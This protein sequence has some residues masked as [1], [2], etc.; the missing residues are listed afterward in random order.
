ME[1]LK[2]KKGFTLI[3]LIVV[4]AI[5]GILMLFLVPAFKGY[6]DDANQMVAKSHA[7][8]VETVFRAT[9]ANLS[10]TG[11]SVENFEFFNQ[12]PDKKPKIILEMDKQ[13][14]E[15]VDKYFIRYNSKI[16]SGKKKTF[17]VWI[18]Y[19]GKFYPYDLMSGTPVLIK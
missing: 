19:K 16:D 15:L 6:L 5:L 10:S 2:N 1:N 7:K 12:T 9:N 13:L 18:N 8:T 3:E 11:E 17:E 4:I 14:G